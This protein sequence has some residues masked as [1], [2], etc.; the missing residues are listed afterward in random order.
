VD[1]KALALRLL[2][3]LTSTGR[4]D[5]GTSHAIGV[6]HGRRGRDTAEELVEAG[7]SP[8]VRTQISPP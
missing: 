5:V 8:T 6:D 4:R 3:V 7:G 1:G 2:T